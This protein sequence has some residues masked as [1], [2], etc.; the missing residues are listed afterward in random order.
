MNQLKLLGA[1]YPSL[2]WPVG[3][4]MTMTEYWHV[5]GFRLALLS[6]MKFGAY[7]TIHKLEDFHFLLQNAQNGCH[8]H[9]VHPKQM[10]SMTFDPKCVKSAHSSFHENLVNS[11][12][13]QNGRLPVDFSFSRG[14]FVDLDMKNMFTK[15]HTC[16][17]KWVLGLQFRGRS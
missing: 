17:Y 6:N 5:N 8:A 16:T 3:G 4:A 11:H 13:V 14:F 12:L 15:F 2:L 9:T 1:E 10:I 7:W